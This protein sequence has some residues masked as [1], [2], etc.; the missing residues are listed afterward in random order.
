MTKANVLW[1]VLLV[2]LLSVTAAGAYVAIR[3]PEIRGFLAYS[4]GDQGAPRPAPVRKATASAAGTSTVADTASAPP[5]REALPPTRAEAA[6]EEDLVHTVEAR[7]LGPSTAPIKDEPPP[8]MLYPFQPIRRTFPDERNIE[9]EFLIQNKSQRFWSPANVAMRSPGFPRSEV[10]RIEKWRFDEIALIRYRF[11]KAE[12][13]SRLK[14]LRVVA[15]TGETIDTPGG[16]QSADARVNMLRSLSASRGGDRG[17]MAIMQG[18]SAAMAGD[19]DLAAENPDLVLDG[20]TVTVQGFDGFP[21]TW[22]PAFEASTP[23]RQELARQMG[24]SHALALTIK[25]DLQALAKMLGEQGYRRTI[26]GE[27]AQ[28]VVRVNESRR[29]FEEVVTKANLA[30]SR[31]RDAE[32]RKA[33]PELDRWVDAVVQGL[34]G[35][36]AQVKLVDPKFTIGGL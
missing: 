28:I 8:T 34:E 2:N 25:D 22:E 6:A 4:D 21:A 10:F 23:E 14:E 13:E 15:V 27:G 36:S 11:P 20:I 3:A 31:T 30:L 9:V 7:Q 35:V 12:L 18:A 29:K 32:L 19:K 5:P 17:L 26:A 16:S 33:Q 24:E 1:S